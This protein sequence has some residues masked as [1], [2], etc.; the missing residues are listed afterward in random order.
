MAIGTINHTTLV[1]NL[2]KDPKFTEH[3]NGSQTCHLRIATTNKWKN[4]ETGEW[5]ESTDWNDAVAFN[6]LGKHIAE[7][8]NKGSRIAI[9]GRLSN[10]QV[11][12]EDV[13]RI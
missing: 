10:G 13:S 6:G 7:K 9:S 5:E 8:F 12:I 11:I 2:G 1:G 3:D 4:R